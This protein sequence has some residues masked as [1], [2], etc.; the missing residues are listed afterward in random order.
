MSVTAPD[1]SAFTGVLWETRE[2]MGTV[3]DSYE[4]SVP[5][6]IGD[7]GASWREIMQRF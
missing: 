4:L 1:D 6:Y 3:E 2:G 5:P 7:S